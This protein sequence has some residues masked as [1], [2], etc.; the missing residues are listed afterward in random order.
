M[1]FTTH[2]N[3]L[4]KTCKTKSYEDFDVNREDKIHD[5]KPKP[6]FYRLMMKLYGTTRCHV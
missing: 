6:P 5:N 1:S 4:T 3:M 2:R